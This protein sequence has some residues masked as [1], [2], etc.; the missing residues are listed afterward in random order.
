M[1][2]LPRGANFKRAKILWELGLHV[3]SRPE[4]P[5][6][7]NRDMCITVGSGS[8]EHFTPSL[9]MATGS[10]ILAHAVV[11]GEVDMASERS[12]LLAPHV[13]VSRVAA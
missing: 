1:E 13:A 9:R 8:G 3:A 6:G 10:A 5:Y 7:G 4:I 12:T 11:R 2:P